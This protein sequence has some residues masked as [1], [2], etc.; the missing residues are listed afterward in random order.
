MKLRV[1]MMAAGKVFLTTTQDVSLGGI[2]LGKQAPDLFKNEEVKLILENKNT[3]RKVQLK[4]AFIADSSRL[5]LRF[6]EIEQKE[7]NELKE[8]LNLQQ[9]AA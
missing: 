3:G 9:K 5:R 2:L 1:F 4:M 7:E 8:W 6:V